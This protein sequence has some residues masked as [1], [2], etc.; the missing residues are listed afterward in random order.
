MLFFSDSTTR[1]L[2]VGNNAFRIRLQM[3]LNDASGLFLSNPYFTPDVIG[4]PLTNRNFS[5]MLVYVCHNGHWRES[6]SQPLDYEVRLL[7]FGHEM[8]T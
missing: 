2:A 1:L 4:E 5:Y 6:N 7:P 3:C 8:R